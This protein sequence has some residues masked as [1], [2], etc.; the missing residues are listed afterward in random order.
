MKTNAHC[1]DEIIRDQLSEVLADLGITP[2]IV[3]SQS[4]DAIKAGIIAE[5]AINPII[6]PVNVIGPANFLEPHSIVKFKISPAVVFPLGRR[7]HEIGIRAGGMVKRSER[8][9]M[10]G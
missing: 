7:R 5:Q 6:A 8:R 9:G 2:R 4:S 3:G 1:E 10:E